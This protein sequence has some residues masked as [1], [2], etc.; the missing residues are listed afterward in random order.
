MKPS[1]KNGKQLGSRIL[2]SRDEALED[3]L[4]LAPEVSDK[5]LSSLLAEYAQK[6]KPGAKSKRSRAATEIP[7]SQ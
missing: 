7:P 3:L 5:E 6:R 2:S 1:R 4:R